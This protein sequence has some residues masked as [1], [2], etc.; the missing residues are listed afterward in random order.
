MPG[1]GKYTQFAPLKVDTSTKGQASTTR[2]QKLFNPPKEL[3]STDDL[4]K[5]ANRFLLAVDNNGV[6]VGDPNQFKSGVSLDYSDAPD[7]AEVKI[8]GGGLPSTPY[9]PNLT[10]PGE[11]NGVSANGQTD[12]EVKR[13]EELNSQAQADVGG[14]KNPKKESATMG[15]TVVIAADK[16]PWVPGAHPGGEG[17]KVTE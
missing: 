10:S 1:Q 12:M 16:N 5:I 9:T 2:L 11:K 7:L 14:L 3:T 13:I 17:L 6:Q 4:F 8:G 15:T